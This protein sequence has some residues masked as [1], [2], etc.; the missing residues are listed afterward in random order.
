M[1][2]FWYKVNNVRRIVLNVSLS[3]GSRNGVSKVLPKPYHATGNDYLKCHKMDYYCYEFI[4]V[5]NTKT[6]VRHFSFTFISTTNMN[7]VLKQT[8]NVAV[9][10]SKGKTSSCTY[11]KKVFGLISN[12][13]ASNALG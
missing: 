1:A 8:F 7:N 4:K 9:G 13:I 2:K 10:I 11:L 12:A 5:K 3:H 6:A